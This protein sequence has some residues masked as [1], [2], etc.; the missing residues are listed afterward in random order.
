MMLSLA[1]GWNVEVER[2]PDWLF[3]RIRDPD[4]LEP[5]CHDLADRVWQLLQQEFSHRLVVEL[6]DIRLLSSSLIGELVRLHKR[7]HTNGGVV[8]LCGLSDSNYEALRTCQLAGRF[9]RYDTREDAVMGYLPAR[10]R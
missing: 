10:P 1:P 5:Q 8:R 7:V 3:V 4:A 6:D 2:G 9:P